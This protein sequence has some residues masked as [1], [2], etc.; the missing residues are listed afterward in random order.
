MNLTRR[1]DAE[2][3]FLLSNSTTASVGD[4]IFSLNTL[5]VPS[6]FDGFYN[7]CM[8]LIITGDDLV[9]ENE[10]V[11]EVDIRPIADRDNVQFPEGSLDMLILNIL[12][13]DG[14]CECY[15]NYQLWFP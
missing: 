13:N 1:R 8:D 7:S 3:S 2:Y 11:I 14:M 12:D 15:F 9:E 10:E 6:G 4:F 5:I